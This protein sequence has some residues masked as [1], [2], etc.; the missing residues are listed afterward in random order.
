MYC[1]YCLEP[2]RCLDDTFV[3]HKDPV[4]DLFDPVYYFLNTLVSYNNYSG[5]PFIAKDC[6]YVPELYKPCK[7]Y[8]LFYCGL[9]HAC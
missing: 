9:E 7:Q 6:G 4:C 8:P 5:P 1:V 3:K 2:L